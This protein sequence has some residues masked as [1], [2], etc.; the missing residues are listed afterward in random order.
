MR[1]RS[2]TIREVVSHHRLDKVAQIADAF[3]PDAV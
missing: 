2:G 1:S 3:A